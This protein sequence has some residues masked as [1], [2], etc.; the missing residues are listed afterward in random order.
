MS[1]GLNVTLMKKLLIGILVLLVFTS[2]SKQNNSEPLN[3]NKEEIPTDN[4]GPESWHSDS[5]E[6]NYQEEIPYT[7]TKEEVSSAIS[8]AESYYENT[9]W[10]NQIISIKQDDDSLATKSNFSFYKEKYWPDKKLIS[11]EVV[12]KDSVAPPRH[13]LLVENEVGGWEFLNEG[14]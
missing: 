12:I 8:A 6:E 10:N 2:C 14:Y 1:K 5:V 13:A 4:F 11:L 9:S 3:E 7:F